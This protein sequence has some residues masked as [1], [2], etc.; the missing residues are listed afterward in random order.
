METRRIAPNEVLDALRR[1]IQVD[2]L[3][4]VLDLDRSRGARLVDARDGRSYL[5]FFSFFA[6]SPLGMNH[7]A[8]TEP[9]FLDRLARVAV[10]KP[11][12]SDIYTDVY[13]EFVD[14]L[15]RVGRPDCMKYF[16]F[17][18]GGALAV[19]N[20]IKVA[21]DWKVRRNFAKG[22]PC[23]RGHQVLH[24]EWAF[25]GRSGYTLSLT[26]TAD[27]RKT[28]YF[29]KFDWPRLPSPAI[30]FPQDAA[31]DARLDQLEA[32]VEARARQA[33]AE[34]K[35]DIAAILIEP[36]QAEGGDRHFR[37]QFLRRLRALCDE[38][39]ALLIFD[40]VQTGVGMT[41]TFWA[42]EQF[43]VEPDLITFAKKMQIG[44][45]MAGPRVDDEP[46]NVFHVSSRINSTWGGHLVDMLRAGRMLQVIEAE[47]LVDNARVQ[48]ARL[49]AGLHEIGR[50]RGELVHN[51]RGR[52]LL[53]AISFADGGTR[54]AAVKA[55]H[56][57]G[58][59]VLPC[60]TDALRF[61]PALNVTP[62]EVDEALNRLDEALATLETTGAV[63]P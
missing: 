45:L 19:E 35:D 55:C 63:T 12:N 61:R 50:A 30:R 26:N 51:V 23:E 57:N 4:L 24:F 53:C 18:D 46:E 60:G 15:D 8:L 10:N 47:R 5:D 21:F 28:M 33:F 7:P 36:I 56:G 41:G 38:F 48:G 40:E 31:E 29:P 27:P 20:A 9:A 16:F 44:G 34:R 43:G 54:D 22:L 11:S 2:G 13:A 39:E 62:A 3:D 32:D 52:G 25:H 1:R 58:L 14:T 49:L 17:V 59:M 37:P 6:S 42:F